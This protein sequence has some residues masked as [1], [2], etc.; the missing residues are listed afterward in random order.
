MKIFRTSWKK[1]LISV[2]M[3]SCLELFLFEIIYSHPLREER[4]LKLKNLRKITRHMNLRQSQEF[5]LEK[6]LLFQG[7]LWNS[8]IADLNWVRASL[9][10]RCLLGKYSYDGISLVQTGGWGNRESHMREIL[11]FKVSLRHLCK[12]PSGHD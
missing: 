5:W 11:I 6:I 10:R 3:I 7:L 2:L 12:P 9:M 1:H 4:G 8:I